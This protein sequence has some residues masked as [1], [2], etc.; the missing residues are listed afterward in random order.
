MTTEKKIDAL[1]DLQPGGRSPAPGELAAVQ[2]FL[3]TPW[4]VV[5]R[6]NAETFVSPKALRDWLEAR[7]LVAGPGRLGTKDLD[8]ALAVREGLRALAFA[9][10][11][12][13]LDHAA[14]DAMRQAAA[15][16]G[17]EVY[18]EPDGPRLVPDTG[19]GIEGAIS[20]L[21]AITARAMI[22]GSWRRLKACRAHHCGWAFY[23]YSRNHSGR[24][25]S[26]KV[27]GDRHNSRA[28]YRRK[29]VG[30]ASGSHGDAD[31]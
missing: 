3:N 11:G 22:D 1:S 27:C 6:R 20:G 31:P 30:R 13:A 4:D 7:G 26:M 29:T 25:C 23:D 19:S 5:R 2:A 12:E 17:V 21:F 15:G 14:I 28:Y 24:W 16:A 9:N 18:I 10:N 8:R